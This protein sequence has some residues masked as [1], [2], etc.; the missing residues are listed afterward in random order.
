LGGL[1]PIAFG[2][3]A[4][5]DKKG[6]IVG[7]STAGEALQTCVEGGSGL[8]RKT[9]RQQTA[10]KMEIGR[11]EQRTIGRIGDNAPPERGGG[12]VI[13][14]LKSPICLAKEL[15]RAGVGSARCRRIR[16]GP[17]KRSRKNQV[18]QGKNNPEYKRFYSN[19]LDFFKNYSPQ[20]T[21][22]TQIKEKKSG[23]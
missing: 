4:V 5:G 11:I 2:V 21:Q 1:V 8:H 18:G 9:G 7:V 19:R 15:L 10:A 14:L 16:V 23:V 13:V 6:Y 22:I 3:G 20:I 12:V 17:V